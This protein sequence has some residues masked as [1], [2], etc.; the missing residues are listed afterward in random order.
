[1]NLN[2]ICPY[3]SRGLGTFS[4]EKTGVSYCTFCEREYLTYHVLRKSRDGWKI[5]ACLVAAVS[6]ALVFLAH[7][8]TRRANVLAQEKAECTSKKSCSAASWSLR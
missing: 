7:A 3:C 1:M 6:L 5:A 2:D 4:T 8:Q